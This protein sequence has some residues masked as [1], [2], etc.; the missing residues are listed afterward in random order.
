[1]ETYQKISTICLFIL[2]MI[3]T[4]Y[5]LTV[6]KTVFIPF[7]LS[8]FIALVI[9][10]VMGKA[11]K[12]LKVPRF[13]VLIGTILFFILIFMMIT[14]VTAESIESFADSSNQYKDKVQQVSTFFAK[15]ANDL[16]FTVEERSVKELTKKIPF[17]QLIKTLSTAVISL[18][19]NTFL[20]IIFCIFLL[21]GESLK[22]VSEDSIITDI[23]ESVGKYVGTKLLVSA[24]TGFLTYLLLKLLNVEMSFM[25]AT[26]TFLLNFIPTIGSI[27][28]VALPLP[29]ILLQFGFTSPFWICLFFLCL[30][31]ITIGN[32]IE[33]KIMGENIGLHPVT[34]L[35]SLAFWGF[36]WGVTGM[37]LS[38][39]IMA[40]LKIVFEKFQLTR[41]IADAF[42]GDLKI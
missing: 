6:T 23:K 14:V 38:V 37:F 28:A 2:T 20:V 5:V 12:K 41:P 1:M 27:I 34:I 29:I 31:Q 33:P 17:T 36:L 7:V 30:I 15:T 39:P 35:L 42:A 40:S 32:I 10:P 26:L 3:A 21:S 25:F 22:D 24:A 16:G 4:A 11:Q 8:V 13:V 19:S 18:F 9:A